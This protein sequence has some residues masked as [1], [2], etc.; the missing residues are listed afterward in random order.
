MWGRDLSGH[1]D[2]E[3]SGQDYSFAAFPGESGHALTK[4]NRRFGAR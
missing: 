4:I 2:G 3:K 1:E